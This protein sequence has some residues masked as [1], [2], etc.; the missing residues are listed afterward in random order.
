MSFQRKR[1]KSQKYSNMIMTSPKRH[2]NLRANDI[3]FEFAM[4]TNKQT[5]K[6]KRNFSQRFL[7]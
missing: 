5:K 3:I 4:W 6:K 1:K 2:Y 7:K